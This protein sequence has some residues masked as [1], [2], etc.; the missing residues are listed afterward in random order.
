MNGDN[1]GKKGTLVI[2]C[3]DTNEGSIHSQKVIKY[4]RLSDVQHGNYN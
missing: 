2:F 4:I 1:Q 3:Q